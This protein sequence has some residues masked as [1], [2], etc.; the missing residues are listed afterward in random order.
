MWKKVRM[1][2]L[3]LL[4]VGLIA[5]SFVPVVQARVDTILWNTLLKGKLTCA[6]PT[7][8]KYHYYPMAFRPGEGKTYDVGGG[9]D[10]LLSTGLSG[11]E[12]IGSTQGYIRMDNKN[13]IMRFRFHLPET[14]VDLG[15]ANDLL[16]Q[17]YVDDQ[18]TSDAAT[19]D[20]SIYEFGSTTPIITDTFTAKY[21]MTAGWVDLDTNSTGIGNDSDIDADDILVVVVTAEVGGVAR[22][23]ADIYGCRIRYRAGIEATEE[24]D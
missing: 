18:V 4:L 22:D 19:Y 10:G 15:D 21:G 8:Y 12:E 7:P 2:V 3:L 20:V 17:F 23:Q 14:F 24:L 6:G 1:S 5:Y 11:I 16:L 9:A 13:D